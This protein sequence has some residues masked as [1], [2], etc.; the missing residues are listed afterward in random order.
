MWVP[1]G[2]EDAYDFVDNEQWFVGPGGGWMEDGQTAGNEMN[3]YSLRPFWAYS[4]GGYYKE[5]VEPWT[6][7]A[8]TWNTYEIEDEERNGRWCARFGN[9]PPVECKG[10]FADYATAVEVGMEASTKSAPENQG[11]DGTTVQFTEGN[12]HF[13]GKAEQ[14]AAN[15]YGESEAG[16]ICIKPRPN[17]EQYPGSARWGT[18]SSTYPC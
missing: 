6:V 2:N 4:I 9:E 7:G 15:N 10:Y 8:D 12:W 11:R 13:W 18:P 5:Y 16:Y 14:E 17:Y 1:G 3:D